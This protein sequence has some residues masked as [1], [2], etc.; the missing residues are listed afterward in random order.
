MP[1]ACRSADSVIFAMFSAILSALST[2]LS[3]ELWVSVAIWLPSE[4]AFSEL[5]IRTVVFFAASWLLDARLR[6]SSATTANPLPASPARAASTAA[7]NARILVWNAISSMVLMIFSISLE[8]SLIL[9]IA[10]TMD[11]ILS[12]LLLISFAVSEINWL[13]SRELAAVS[14]TWLDSSP[15]VAASSSTELACS[16]APWLSA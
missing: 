16:V 13:T 12:L 7:F 5:L 4:T 6:T 3:S 9:L 11:S 15:R 14:L 10:R 8:H 1:S 2:T